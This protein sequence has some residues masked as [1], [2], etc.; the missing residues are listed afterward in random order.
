MV[1]PTRAISTEDLI[2]IRASTD[3]RESTTIEWQG[4]VLYAEL[5]T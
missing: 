5:E 3:E 4:Q 2:R 1:L